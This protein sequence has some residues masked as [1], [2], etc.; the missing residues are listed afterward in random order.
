MIMEEKSP[1][2]EIMPLEE[3]L[4]LTPEERI[5]QN[6]IMANRWLEVESFMEK[7]FR[8]WNFIHSHH[9]NTR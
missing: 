5:R 4:R 9:V 8:G 6:N 3:F 2:I 7:L 1:I